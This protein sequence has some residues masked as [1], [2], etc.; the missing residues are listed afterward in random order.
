[1]RHGPFLRASPSRSSPL[2]GADDSS[3]GRGGLVS[4]KL[5]LA[6]GDTLDLVMGANGAASSVSR[7]GETLLLA[8]GGDGSQP[9][10]LGPPRTVR[11]TLAPLPLPAKALGDP[12]RGD[13]AGR[14]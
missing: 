9:N 1:M 4:A 14:A 12:G 2:Y 3:G 8:G 7:G 10:Y 13:Q 5:P 6:V 11:Q